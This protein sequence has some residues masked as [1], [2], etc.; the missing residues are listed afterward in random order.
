MAKIVTDLPDDL[1]I[2]VFQWLDIVDLTILFA[3][4]GRFLKLASCNTLWKNLEAQFINVSPMERFQIKDLCR[5][6]RKWSKGQGYQFRLQHFN[7]NFMPWTQLS[8]DKSYF[9]LSTG[10]SIQSWKLKQQLRR[11]GKSI[12]CANSYAK[13]EPKPGC[14]INKFCVH[15]DMMI[16]AGCKGNIYWKKTNGKESWKNLNSHHS[17]IFALDFREKSLVTGSRGCLKAWKIAEDLSFITCL[18]SVK[19]GDKV[20][21]LEMNPVK[22]EFFLGSC[23]IK[24]HPL[25]IWDLERVEKRYDLGSEFKLGAGAL[26][27]QFLSKDLLIT[28]GYDT[29]IRLWDTRTSLRNCVK[30]WEEPHDNTIYCVTSDANHMILS[31]SCRHGVVRL[32]DMR[33]T[34]PV[35]TFYFGSRRV[36]S[37]VYSLQFTRT[38]LFAALAR[39]LHCVE[40]T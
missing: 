36:S 37:P 10:S 13:F 23:G 20:C 6:S 34:K 18:S 29:Y 30:I 26:D 17:D 11:S 38:H 16:G 7:E 39:G 9:F 5:I 28:A 14:D 24:S 8:D 27:T 19:F 21:S 1:W 25:Q 15:S 31:G 22:P 4:C 32:W 2:S 33:K 3:V 12:L 40:F 35:Q